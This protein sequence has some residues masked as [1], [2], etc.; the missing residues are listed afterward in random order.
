MQLF[1]KGELRSTAPSSRRYDPS[2]D[3][4]GATPTDPVCK[5]VNLPLKVTPALDS[6]A[7]L[8]Q[9]PR[10]MSTLAVASA[11]A[12]QKTATVSEMDCMVD[13]D[14]DE[15]QLNYGTKKLMM[16]GILIRFLSLDY[17]TLV[18]G[19]TSLEQKQ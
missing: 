10:G 16:T 11:V 3:V 14:A 6:T 19:S 17:E 18:L 8:A 2:I 13:V 1:A 5:V 4:P 7:K 15:K 9:L 12:M